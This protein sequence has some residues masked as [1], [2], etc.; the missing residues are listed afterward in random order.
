MQARLLL[1]LRKHV[2]CMYGERPCGVQHLVCML[3]VS[4]A[5][6][7][8]MSCVRMGL[9][10][11]CRCGAAVCCL[12]SGAVE[13]RL[14]AWHLLATGCSYPHALHEQLL[15]VVRA[16]AHSLVLYRSAR[17]QLTKGTHV[18]RVYLQILTRC[19]VCSLL[20][21]IAYAMPHSCLCVL[22]RGVAVT[23]V[24]V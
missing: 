14:C 5:S 17:L 13:T 23:V 12:R 18:M 3:L 1:L 11:Q 16:A 15:G 9:P 24:P 4:P 10:E 19:A 22:P 8:F 20:R 6:V 2:L 21:F 7:L